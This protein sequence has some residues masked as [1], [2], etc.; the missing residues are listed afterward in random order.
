MHT[1]HNNHDVADV[2]VIYIYTPSGTWALI[3]DIGRFT[4][5]LRLLDAADAPC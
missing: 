5:Q 2:G 4:G 1:I 3:D